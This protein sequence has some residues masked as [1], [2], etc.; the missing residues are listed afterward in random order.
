MLAITTI[1]ALLLLLVV[2]NAVL[3]DDEKQLLRTS[4]NTDDNEVLFMGKCWCEPGWAPPDCKKPILTNG[5]CDCYPDKPNDRSFLKN[6]TWTHPKGYRC[7]AL[8]KWNKDVGVARAPYTEWKDN[9]VWRQLSFYQKDLPKTV[10]HNGTHLKARLDEFNEGFKGFTYLKGA[11]FGDVIELGC[12][13][14]TQLRN[15][16]E[17][18]PIEVKSVTLV[19]PQINV[20]KN[21]E[22][23]SYASGQ[24]KAMGKTFPTTLHSKCTEDI[25]E[26]LVTEGFDT[27]I[28]MN[29][30]VYARDA[31]K[32]LTTMYRIL[33][34][35]K[36]IY[37]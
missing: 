23:C 34:P 29:V 19:D 21:I 3:A 6:V 15:V 7:E 24:L 33:K 4:C 31:F 27:V 28:H 26:V 20:Y 2:M 9:Q 12:G 11:D 37:Q 13:G 8:C 10:K 25:P 22:G 18:Q 35:G 17:R 14:Y 30:L 32:Y 16:L 1:C 5:D 36:F